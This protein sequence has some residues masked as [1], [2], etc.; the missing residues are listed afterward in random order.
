MPQEHKMRK[1][2]FTY[3]RESD[4]KYIGYLNE[5]PDHWTQGD[6]LGDLKGHLLDLNDLFGDEEIPGIKKV[7]ELEVA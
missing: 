5:Y 7:A 1:I 6:D 3:W 4:G 2:L